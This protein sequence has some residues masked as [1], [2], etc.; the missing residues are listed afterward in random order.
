[1]GPQIYAWDDNR[2]PL[3]AGASASSGFFSALGKKLQ[4]QERALEPGEELADRGSIYN[5]TETKGEA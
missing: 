1:M 5:T 4:T 3:P 2:L